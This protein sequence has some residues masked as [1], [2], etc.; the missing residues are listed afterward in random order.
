MAQADGRDLTRG[1]SRLREELTDPRVLQ[2]SGLWSRFLDSTDQNPTNV[3]RLMNAERG[4][5]AIGYYDEQEEKVDQYGAMLEQRRE[6]VLSKQT[7]V[8]PASES[9]RDQAIAEFLEE[10]IAGIPEWRAKLS[11]MLDAIGKGVSI[12]EL[13]YDLDGGRVVLRDIRFRYQGH[14]AFGDLAEPEIGPLR[15]AYGGANELLPEN[16]FLVCTFGGRRGNRW[17]RPLGRRCFWPSWF[18]RMGIRFWLKFVEKGTGT[19]MSKYPQ[20]A[21]DD[22]QALALSAA[23]AAQDT[24]AVA[25]PETFVLEMLDGARQGGTGTYETL[26]RRCESAIAKIVLG[27][28]LTSAG[29]DQG[30]GSRALGDVHADVRQEKIEADAFWLE[31]CITQEIFR[32][33]VELN[34]GVGVPIPRFKIEAEEGED[35]GEAATLLERGKKLGLRISRTYAHERLQIPEAEEGDEGVLG[36]A[37][38]AGQGAGDKGQDGQGQEFG[39]AAADPEPEKVTEQALDQ[40]RPV[41]RDLID[42]LLAQAMEALPE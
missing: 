13:M 5:D 11:E 16:K 22:V 42:E 10:Q 3:W 23:V 19:V 25:I 36:G 4:A 39:E 32:P 35:L 14:F 29:S 33:L 7:Q 8:L 20:G 34:F 15:L 9:S 41:H 30:S 21:E 17:G 18:L 1:D 38:D 28:T 24:T 37:E 27:Q 31:R 12:A 2:A 26:V 6:A 40:A